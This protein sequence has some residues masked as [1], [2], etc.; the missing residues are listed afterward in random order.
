MGKTLIIT[1][2]PSVAR[3]YAKILNVSGKR[4]GFIENENYIIT[5]C[6]GH[7][8]EMCYPDKYDKQYAK[9]N[10]ADL[11]FGACRQYYSVQPPGSK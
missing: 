10:M 4:D 11:P 9:W 2:K 7:L 5:W 6:V 1:E 3:E 8:I